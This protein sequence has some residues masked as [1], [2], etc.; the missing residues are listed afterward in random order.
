MSNST[1]W[2]YECKFCDFTCRLKATMRVH[3]IKNHADKIYKQVYHLAN[4]KIKLVDLE[5]VKDARRNRRV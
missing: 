2:H 3:V 1:A 5:E 4:D